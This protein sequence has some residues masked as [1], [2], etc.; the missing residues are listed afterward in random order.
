MLYQPK[1]EGD[2]IA[3]IAFIN[4]SVHALSNIGCVADYTIYTCWSILELPLD[5]LGI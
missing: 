3:V 4:V 1:S 5:A 2:C